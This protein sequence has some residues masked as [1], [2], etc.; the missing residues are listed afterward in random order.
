MSF[1]PSSRSRVAIVG[2][3]MIIAV[4]VHVGSSGSPDAVNSDGATVEEQRSAA[5]FGR[6]AAPAHGG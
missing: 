1:K 6:Q 3:W 2:A 5:D 4:T